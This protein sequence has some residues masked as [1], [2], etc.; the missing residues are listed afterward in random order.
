MVV[1][2]DDGDIMIRKKIMVIFLTMTL[3]CGIFSGCRR[4]NKNFQTGNVSSD[5]QNGWNIFNHPV[6]RGEGGYYFLISHSSQ[7]VEDKVEKTR[8]SYMLIMFM[9]DDGNSVVVCSKPECKHNSEECPACLSLESNNPRYDENGN[10]IPSIT[11]YDRDKIYYHNG[12]IYVIYNDDVAGYAYLEEVAPNGAYRTRLFEIGNSAKGYCLT[13]NDQDVF[14]YKREGSTSGYEETEA[15]IRRRSLDGKEDEVIYSYKGMGAMLFA[16]KNYGDKLYF[17]EELYARE[18]DE[19]GRQKSISFQRKGLFAYDYQSKTVE[20]VI[21]AAITDYTFDTD[22]NTLYYYVNNDG[23]YKKTFNDGKTQKIYNME[24]DINSVAQISFLSGNIYLVNCLMGGFT[25][26]PQKPT[27]IVFDKDGK[28]QNRITI[29]QMNS[30]IFFGD[31][32]KIFLQ[33]TDMREGGYSLYYIDIKDGKTDL[34][35]VKIK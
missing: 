32:D 23:M 10:V 9:Q 5:A 30:E 33:Q 15:T 28:E 11:G 6:T 4:D 14:I 17:L 35:M 2:R 1:S 24:K 13:F 29:S 16:V 21:D 12:K 20:N 25:G 34:S 3:V 8:S 22:N 19:N 26:I 7:I 18:Q 27:L 31:N